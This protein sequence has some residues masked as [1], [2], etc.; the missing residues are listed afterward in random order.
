MTP[1]RKSCTLCTHIGV[2]KGS[3]EP[4]H[5][6]TFEVA[7]SFD[8]ALDRVEPITRPSSSLE[9]RQLSIWPLVEGGRLYC[10]PSGIQW[11]EEGES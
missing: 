5:S 6:R 8:E 7:V 3:G 1:S 4:G 9:Q 11:I 10:P 2:E